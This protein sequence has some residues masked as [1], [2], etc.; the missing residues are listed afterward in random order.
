MDEAIYMEGEIFILGGVPFKIK[1][2]YSN[3]LYSCKDEILNL[4]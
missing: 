3:N 4:I 2:T 1:G